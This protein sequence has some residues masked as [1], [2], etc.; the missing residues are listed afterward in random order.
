VA[1]INAGWST[2]YPDNG[3]DDLSFVFVWENPSDRNIVVNVASYLMLNGFCDV[4][5]EA[6]ASDIFSPHSSAL[7]FTVELGV[8][9]YWNNPPTS[10]SG[11]VGQFASVLGLN[12]DGGGIFGFGDY[13][14]SGVSGIYDVTYGMFQIPPKG[15]TVFVVRLLIGHYTNGGFI[16][17][18]FASG[19]FE[20]MCPALVIAILT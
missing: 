6:G 14:S 2:P 16:E 9:E 18:D 8:L 13:E 15:V 5:A 4:L 7:G 1:K 12:A 20:V 11:Q 3:F 19:D 10:P 17:V